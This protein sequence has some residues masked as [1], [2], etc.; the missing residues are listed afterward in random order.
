MHGRGGGGRGGR[1]GGR[2]GKGG[3]GQGPGPWMILALGLCTAYGVARNHL[4]CSV[5]LN[6]TA[7]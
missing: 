2:E 1:G 7:I 6:S 5:V 4:D 3:E